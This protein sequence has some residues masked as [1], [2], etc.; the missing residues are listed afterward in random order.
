MNM[1]RWVRSW[2]TLAVI[3]VLVAALATIVTI[4][5]AGLSRADGGWSTTDLSNAGETLPSE[6]FFGV[7]WE[8]GNYYSDGLQ[9]YGLICYPKNPVFLAPYPVLIVNHGLG[10]LTLPFPGIVNNSLTGCI[11]MARAGWLVAT[12][13]YRDETIENSGGPPVFGPGFMPKT[14]G[15]VVELCGGE[16]HDVLNLLSAVKALNRGGGKNRQTGSGAHVESFPR[17]VHHGAGD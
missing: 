17:F 8:V 13:T 14:S 11:E 9:I 3:V 12:S 1:S 10:S 6:D 7:H 15:G 4:Q 2:T 5:P 16:V